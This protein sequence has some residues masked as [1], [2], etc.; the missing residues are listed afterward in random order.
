MKKIKFNKNNLND[1]SSINY[2]SYAKKLDRKRNNHIGKKPFAKKIATTDMYTLIEEALFPEKFH[3]RIYE[4]LREDYPELFLTREEM[5]INIGI[6]L[7]KKKISSRSWN[8]SRFNKTFETT[9]GLVINEIGQICI[10]N[11]TKKDYKDDDIIWIDEVPPNGHDEWV[12][13]LRTEFSKYYI[14]DNE[15]FKLDLKRIRKDEGFK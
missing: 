1:F 3:E 5:R 7:W 13:R 8:T 6:N 10:F 11:A 9:E 4:Y 14:E 15:E 12:N 2:S